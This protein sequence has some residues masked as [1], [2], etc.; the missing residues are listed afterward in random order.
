MYCRCGLS[1]HLWLSQTVILCEGLLNCIGIHLLIA[2]HVLST[3]WVHIMSQHVLAVD[4]ATYHRVCV[5]FTIGMKSWL[6]KV[7]SKC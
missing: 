2:G 4:V 5:G 6:S 1:W 7:S 3:L